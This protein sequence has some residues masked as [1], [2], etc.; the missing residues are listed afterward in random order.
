MQLRE[1][2][3]NGIVEGVIY[4][5]LLLFFFPIL[6]GTLFQQL[7][8]MVDA[9]IVGNFVG[10]EALAAVGG[11]T[12]TM[13]NLL[14][15]FFVGLA[16]G[17]GVII[18]QYYGSK[19]EEGVKKGVHTATAL[20]VAGGLILMC[21]GL[22]LAP[23][24]LRLMRVNEDVMGYAL[25]YIRVYFLGMI[26]TALYN[27]GAGMLRAIGDS[28]RPLYYLIVACAANVILDFLFVGAFRWGIE[29][30]AAATVLSQLGNMLLTFRYLVKSKECYG[31]SLKE[32]R[33]HS[34]E[35]RK[36]LQLGIPTGLQSVLYAISN[37]IIQAG[38]NSFGTDSVAALT[39]F[40]K[41]DGIFWMI[42]SAF[43]IAVTTFIGQNFGARKYLR[44]K[45][46][47]RVSLGMAFGMAAVLCV[48][49]LLFVEPFYHAF[50]SDSAVIA[51]GVNAVRFLMPMY[52]TYVCIEVLSGTMRGAGESLIPMV[53]TA[54]GV[55]VVRVLWVIL[56]VPHWHVLNVLMLSY[57]VSWTV[58]SVVF[59]IYYQSGVW[60]RRC[61]K[62]SYGEMELENIKAQK[63]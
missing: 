29:G 27:V 32:V 43:G 52:L 25:S 15:G 58:T 3:Q 41:L 57:P 42:L 16:S 63:M 51:I 20:G 6:F 7:Y 33:F 1:P 53:I 18:S 5:Q 19:D 13:I 14:L 2:K 22:L 8:T 34:G 56:V 26:P 62:R 17:A 44:I 47:V 37:M 55:C 38:I 23:M 28:K 4:K 54:L 12:G 24:L 50:T 39:V 59:L 31:L 11:T 10:K 46:A 49:C 60:L 21:A 9:A 40:E 45:K 61:V 30:A 48:L 35:L 36:M